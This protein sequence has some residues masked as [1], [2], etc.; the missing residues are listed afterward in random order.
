M[1]LLPTNLGKL[2]DLT[3]KYDGC[4]ALSN[5]RLRVHGDNTFTAEATDT[6]CL[7]RVTGPC[8]APAD[9]F[10]DCV[11]GLTT[12]PNGKTDAAHRGEPPGRKRSVPR[13][14]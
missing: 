12:A 8:V 1:H 13:R 14:S 2:A 4:F 6:K 10:P 11:P 7:L 9:Q 3:E 5:V